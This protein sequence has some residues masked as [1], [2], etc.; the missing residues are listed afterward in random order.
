MGWWMG[1]AYGRTVSFGFY[2]WRARGKATSFGLDSSA[3]PYGGAY[4]WVD[5][6]PPCSHA[7]NACAGYGYGL[8]LC[9]QTRGAP[10]KMFEFCAHRTHEG[11]LTGTF[12]YVCCRSPRRW[13][14]CWR[15]WLPQRPTRPRQA[16][17]RRTARPPPTLRCRSRSWCR[18]AGCWSAWRR[19]SAAWPSW[20]T[21]ARCDRIAGNRAQTYIPPRLHAHCLHQPIVYVT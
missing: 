1:G 9:L 16:A 17:R 11:L 8:A 2:S 6:G 3:W 20:P 10:C 5:N 21:R 15:R 19:R 13:R 4:V 12:S 18:S 7:Q 14:S